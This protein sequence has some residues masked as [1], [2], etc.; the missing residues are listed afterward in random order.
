VQV[1]EADAETVVA[2]LHAV[3]GSTAARWAAGSGVRFV[4]EVAVVH[5]WSDAKG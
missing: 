4:A 1:R 2:A 5:R 3:L